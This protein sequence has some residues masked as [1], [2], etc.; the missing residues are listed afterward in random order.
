MLDHIN[1][2]MTSVDAGEAE[3]VQFR[4]M[5]EYLPYRNIA[6]VTLNASCSLRINLLTKD[7]IG[8][9]RKKIKQ[10]VLHI[11][12]LVREAVKKDLGT[13]WTLKM[14]VDLLEEY[15]PKEEA[16]DIDRVIRWIGEVREECANIEGK[17]SA[18]IRL[19]VFRS[20]LL[21]SVKIQTYSTNSIHRS[22]SLLACRR[23]SQM[24]RLSRWYT[25]SVASFNPTFRISLK[26][27]AVRCL[28]RLSFVVFAISRARTIK[29]S[30]ESTSRPPSHQHSSA[31]APTTSAEWNTPS[32]ASYALKMVQ[33]YLK[34]FTAGCD[35]PSS[36]S[37]QGFRSFHPVGDF[38]FR[39]RLLRTLTNA[40]SE[41]MKPLEIR[42]FVDG[43]L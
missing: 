4:L 22:T 13:K 26:T 1:N 36:R 11:F 23:E 42:N 34:R 31:L 25:N 18:L 32:F 3:R 21:L 30:P 8:D 5:S 7:P 28:S 41:V 14:D 9:M 37:G 19:V 43:R 2:K 24:A 6:I 17:D 38:V 16:P 20:Q 12:R 27:I 33:M 10:K 15:R 35:D 40:H 29:S 39:V